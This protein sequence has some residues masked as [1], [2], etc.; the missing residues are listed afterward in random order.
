MT[1]VMTE[2]SVNESVI[3]GSSCLHI[4]K[5]RNCSTFLI[6]CAAAASDSVYLF[7]KGVKM[8]VVRWRIGK[9]GSDLAGVTGR[10]GSKPIAKSRRSVFLGR[11]TNAS[12]LFYKLSLP[13][14]TIAT[15]PP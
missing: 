10:S 11:C 1:E 9:T 2:V 5:K 14:F 7:G 6:S 12:S 13:N 4:F 15:L 3:I 8:C